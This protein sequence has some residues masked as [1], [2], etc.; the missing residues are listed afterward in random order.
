MFKKA[1]EIKKPIR[2]LIYGEAGVGKTTLLGTLPSPVAII[3]FEGG[4]GVRFS[5]RDDI[6]IAEVS[7]K[8]ELE[9]AIAELPNLGAKSIAFDGFSVYLQARLEEIVKQYPGRSGSVEF[10]HWNRLFR[11][12]KYLILN[13]LRNPQAHIVFT[14]LEKVERNEKGEI[15]LIRPD[16]S[17]GVRRYLRGLVDLEGR[18]WEYEGKRILSF[19]TNTGQMEVKDRTGRLTAK[20]DPDFRKILKKIYEP[21]PVKAQNLQEGGK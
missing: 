8:E 15:E 17:K 16:I 3:D 13:L 19:K 2:A 18:L 14:A 4:A 12:A 5:N 20:E 7:S 1:S 10:K 6:F 21:L 9:E 11:E